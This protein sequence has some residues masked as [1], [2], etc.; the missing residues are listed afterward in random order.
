MARAR[1]FILFINRNWLF[2][3]Q[4]LP[5]LAERFGLSQALRVAPLALCL[6]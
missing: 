6:R 2:N 3:C 4:V 1:Q 5:F